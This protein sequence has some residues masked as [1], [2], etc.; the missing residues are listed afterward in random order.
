M[1]SRSVNR[2]VLRPLVALACLA[3]GP[4]AARGQGG[5]EEAVGAA[6]EGFVRAFEARDPKAMAAHW[7]EGAEYHNLEGR[8]VHGRDALE[9]AFV[10]YFA[11]TPEVSAALRPDATRFLAPGAAMAEGSVTVRRGPVDPA[12][13]ARYSALVLKEGDAWRIAQLTETPEP[14]ES[15]DDLEWLIGEWRSEAGQGAEVRTTYSWA[16]NRKF[17]HAEFTV[18]E[19]SMSLT[20]FQVIGVDPETQ[21]LRTWTFEANGGVAEA[22]WAR[23]GDHWVLDAAGTLPDGRT[24]TETN[25]LRRVDANTLTWQSVRRALEDEELPDLAPVKITRV[26]AKK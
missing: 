12:T 11:R 22:D 16:P 19:P 10:A 8:T 24:L 14:G 26:E 6:L 3:A 25:V 13:R 21:A 5:D 17:I 2:A 7:T 18:E 20:G 1:S 9:K 23:D 15:I 4:M